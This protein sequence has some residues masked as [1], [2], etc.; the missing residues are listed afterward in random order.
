MTRGLHNRFSRHW[1]ARGFTLIEVL[2]S[3][4]IFSIGLLGYI[5]L[6]SMVQARQLEIT[7]RLYALQQVDLLAAQLAANPQDRQQAEN[8][9]N[10]WNL[11]VHKSGLVNGRG[12]ID[13][14][15]VNDSYTVT[16]AWQ[17]LS[18]TSEQPLSACGA[19]EYGADGLRR[20]VSR[21]IYISMPASLGS[22]GNK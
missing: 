8:A 20:I 6:G 22:G 15:V 17:G 13:D 21:N 2:V 16:V 5:S 11:S 14:A 1:F 18:E 10:Q 4:L 12:C 7:Q 3:L 9:F 19:G